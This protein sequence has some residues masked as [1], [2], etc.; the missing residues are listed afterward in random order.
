MVVA[1][2]LATAGV[3]VVAAVVAVVA[4]VAMAGVTGGKA[5]RE[6]SSRALHCTIGSTGH[7]HPKQT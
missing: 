6:A 2:D 3:T 7:D 4:A 1:A 5:V